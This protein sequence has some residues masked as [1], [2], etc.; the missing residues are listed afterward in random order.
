[1]ADNQAEDEDDESFGDFKYVSYPNQ[2]TYSNQMNGSTVDDDDDDWSDF[3]TNTNQINDVLEPFPSQSPSKISRQVSEDHSHNIAPHTN[4]LGQIELAPRPAELEKSRW[5]KP[6]GALPLSIFGEGED[7]EPAASN[8]A[9]AND[10]DVFFNKAGDSVKK[11][12]D[13]SGSFIINDII[14]NLYNQSPQLNSENGSISILSGAYLNAFGASFNGN[15]SISTVAASPPNPDA[16]GLN[17]NISN[18]NSDSVDGYED[19]DDDDDGWEFKCA[20]PE[21]QNKSHNIKVEETSQKTNQQVEATFGFG[22]GNSAYDFGSMLDLSNGTS[23]K[24]DEWKMGFE[25]S[26]NPILQDHTAPKLGEENKS[27]NTKTGL[28]LVNENFG[29]FKDA[30]SESETNHNS[31]VPKLADIYP[32][33]EE[34]L[35]YDGEGPPDPIDQSHASKESS[36]QSDEWDFGFNFNPPS[37]GEDHHISE[38]CSNSK[39][40]DNNQNSNITPTNTNVNSGVQLSK[41]RDAITKIGIQYE[42]SQRSSENRRE[43]LPLSIFGDETPDIDDRSVYQDFS[44]YAPT[45]SIRNSFNNPSSNLSIND[46][47]WNLYSQP[48]QKASPNS[49]PKAMENG[50]HETPAV[51]DPSL[52]NREDD[53]N[54]GSWEFIGASSGNRLNSELSNAGN[55]FENDSL[56][57]KDT[58]SGTRSQDQVSV[59]DHRN[60]PMQSS[61]KIESLGY[62]D[63]YCKLKDELCNAILCHLQN[64][65]KVQI[66]AG[67]S[68]EDAK[69]KALHEEIQEFSVMLHQGEI[70]PKEYL[71]ENH[72]PRNMCLGELLEVFEE[73]KFQ[74]LESEYNLRSTLSLAEKDIVP[75]IELLK[76]AVSTLRILD[77]G[78]REDQSNYLTMWSKIACV[79]CRELKHGAFIWKESVQK[80]VHD[81]IL[82]NPKG[83]RYFH[84]LGEIYRVAVIVGASAKLYKPWVLSGSSDATSLFT[85]LNDCNAIWSDSG[86]EEALSSMM[87]QTKFEQDGILRE[88]L[89]SIKYIHELDEHALQSYVFS[90]PET[91]QLSA[92][93]ADFIP[94]L[95]MVAWNGK[96]YFLTVANLW[97]NLIS[98]DPPK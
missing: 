46:L 3:I 54:D 16:N 33:S 78:S 67:V 49:T 43:A 10:A 76:H 47:I 37:L 60:S 74:Y 63:L 81:Q 58:F 75:A 48:Q 29:V 22:F 41:C 77:M 88:L 86:L 6:Q 7:D 89:E 26:R 94:G 28:N 95:K 93:P 59:I 82:S 87:N 72:S 11:G 71:S 15:S 21:I 68:S 2:P 30:Y 8:L 44:S 13:S 18:L 36:L 27:N 79:C 35:K 96:H 97:A 91:C 4:K 70:I 61:A 57:F 5:T 50:V 31:E 17:S 64:L 73:P 65:K 53:F 38:S 19:N 45:S 90:G 85:L 24:V 1:M 66:I 40:D 25:Y 12:S 83:I 9:F 62:V 69:A 42:K 51:S 23:H 20:E 55:G 98:S 32:T 14:S 39:Q 56:E 92:L 84:A 52:V 34:A 80:N